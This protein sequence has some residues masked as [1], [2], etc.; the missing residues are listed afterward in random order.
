MK[1]SVPPGEVGGVL[2]GDRTIKC[3][4]TTQYLDVKNRLFLELQF[5]KHKGQ[6]EFSKYENGV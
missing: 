2:W 6:T 5:A 3:V 4:E 1:F